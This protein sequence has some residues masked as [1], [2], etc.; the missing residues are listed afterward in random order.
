MHTM[1]VDHPQDLLSRATRLLRGNYHVGFR[2]TNGK[3]T[4]LEGINPSSKMYSGAIWN[5]DT[6]KIAIVVAGF[7][8]HLAQRLME[9]L[10]GFQADNGSIPIVTF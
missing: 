4:M 1:S 9:T 8:P 5:W 2:S 3:V 7:D 10:I 6:A